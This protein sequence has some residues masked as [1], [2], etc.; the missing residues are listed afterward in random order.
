MKSFKYIPF[1]FSLFLALNIAKADYLRE[2]DL[3]KL[4]VSCYLENE[5]PVFC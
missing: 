1:I 2:D 3:K 4:V 5:A